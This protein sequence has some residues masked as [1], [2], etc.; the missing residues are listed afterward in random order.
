MKQ[1]TLRSEQLDLALEVEIDE[2]AHLTDQGYPAKVIGTYQTTAVQGRA[3]VEFS[4]FSK[5]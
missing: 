2:S 4:G 1:W 5:K 3:W